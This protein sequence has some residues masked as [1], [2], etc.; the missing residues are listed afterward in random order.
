MAVAAP[1]QSETMQPHVA[2]LSSPG[3]GHIIPLLELAKRLATDHGCHVSFLNITAEASAAQTQLLRAPDLPPN[4]HVIDL[5]EA[6]VSA[7]VS[8]ETPIL[9]RLS[10]IVRENLRCLK[11]VLL[12][13]GKPKALVI[14]LFCTQAFEVCEELSIPVYSFCTPSAALFTFSLYLPTL[15]RDVV[16]SEFVDLPEPIR[17]PGCSPIRPEDLLDQV[18]NR[19]SE[20]YEWFFL[21]VS[22]LPLAAG[23]FLNTW[24]ELEP[25]TLRAIRENPFYHQR[26]APPVYPVG[27]LVKVTEPITESDAECLTW[28]DNQP[29]DSVVFVAL[30]SGGT[31]STAQVTEVAWGLELSGQRFIWV[32]RAPTEADPSATFFNVGGEAND[33]KAFLPDGFLERTKEVGHV[34]VSW[35]PQVAVLRHPSTGAFW[36]HCGWN[37]TL[38]SMTHGV[39]M[40]AWPLYAEQRMNATVLAE[41]VGVAVKPVADPGKGVVARE[42]VKRV[43]SLV[44]KGEE[45]KA[46]RH[47]A[48]QL[49]ESAAKALGCDGGSSYDSLSRLANDWRVN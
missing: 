5:P 24:E 37:S 19:K 18:R 43:V 39:P 29:P 1:P 4:L 7:L 44:I 13:L 38:E 25:V 47:R 42:E 10:I 48:R 33:P 9:T 22:R 31:L 21:H 49:K 40:I 34:V 28:L 41:D 27:P 45:G 3:M 32:V 12:D 36:S 23:V 14:D 26:P 6:D 17:V 20:E 15:D 2:V 30:G 46:M 16:D 8:S 35:A 11:T